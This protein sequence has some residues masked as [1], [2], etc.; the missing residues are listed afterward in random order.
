[1]AAGLAGEKQLVIAELGGTLTF[2][3]LKERGSIWARLTESP[4]TIRLRQG[5]ERLR[6]DCKRPRRSLKN[7]LREAAI[8]PWERETLPL[9]FSGEHLA[10]VPGIGV[11]CDFQAAG[12]GA[13]STDAEWHY[14]A[15]PG[16]AG[17]WLLKPRQGGRTS[18]QPR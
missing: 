14:K 11:D 6:P 8:P 7:L 10:C 17:V 2:T 9:I 15:E 12:R 13:G 1:M 18:C 5:G 3:P 16:L 4:V